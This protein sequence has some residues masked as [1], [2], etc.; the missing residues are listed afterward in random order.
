M[1]H[2]LALLP[3]ADGAWACLDAASEAAAVE[4]G[5]DIV[6]LHV[7]VDPTQ[8]FTSSEEVAFQRL[9]EAREGT[10]EQRAEATR[11]ALEQWRG[12]VP[13]QISARVQY[14][15][16]VGPEEANV[17][18]ESAKA[19]FLV[20]TRPHNLDGH[21]AF[22]AAVF[23]SHKPV[24]L[25]PPNWSAIADRPLFHHVLIGWKQTP[26][27]HRAVKAALPWLRRAGRVTILTVRKDGQALDTSELLA[28]LASNSVSADLVAAD[29]IEG[30]TS[31]RLLATAHEIGATCLVMGA[32]RFGSLIEWALGATTRRTIAEATIS[33]LLGH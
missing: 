30:R 10:A 7:K 15:E 18:S 26:Q 25:T 5:T 14:V 4:P 17:I 9:R 19:D 31:A 1:T 27:A 2:I 24:L 8:Y 21:D 28:M 16:K 33:L 12:R 22:H 6:A 20:M 29:P 11:N 23:V 32:Y 3:Q 13:T